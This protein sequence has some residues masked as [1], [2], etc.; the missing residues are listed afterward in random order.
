[1][2][3]KSVSPSS[4]DETVDASQRNLDSDSAKQD[5]SLGDLRALIQDV[6]ASLPTESA[7]SSEAASGADGDPD[8]DL[9]TPSESIGWRIQLQNVA[10]GKEL[11]FPAPAVVD[12]SVKDFL[13]RNQHV[14]FARD[15]QI[16]GF[17]KGELTLVLPVGFCREGNRVVLELTQVSPTAKGAVASK[18]P[19]PEFV[20]T[21][22]AEVKQVEDA[23]ETSQLKLRLLQFDQGSW[24]RFTEIYTKRQ[25]EIQ[26]LF[27]MNRH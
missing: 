14:A 2:K 15:I 26:N 22:T 24:Q 7:D 10:T 11:R 17:G 16:L 19:V 8:W 20:F 6:E 3:K 13:V 21:S 27:R 18:T 23:Y 25:M 9:S 12:K 1:M 5:S 4:G